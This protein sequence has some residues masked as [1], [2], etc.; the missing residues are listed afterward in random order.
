[1]RFVRCITKCFPV[2]TRDLVAIALECYFATTDVDQMTNSQKR[3]LLYHWYATN[4]YTIVGKYK[5]KELPRCLVSKIREAYPSPDG[6]YK[7][8][9]VAVPVGRDVIA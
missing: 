2:Q 8:F 5:R 4:I 1:M 7:E 6:I 3:N 9:E